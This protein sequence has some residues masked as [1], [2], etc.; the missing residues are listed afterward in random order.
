VNIKDDTYGSLSI[1]LEVPRELI[2]EESEQ[3]KFGWIFEQKI[4]VCPTENKYADYEKLF[5]KVASQFTLWA[6]IFGKLK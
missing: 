6:K 1:S 5:L 3:F 4:S 2:P